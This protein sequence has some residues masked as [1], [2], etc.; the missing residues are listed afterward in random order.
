MLLNPEEYPFCANKRRENQ[1]N[2]E[3]NSPNPNNVS[4]HL[5]WEREQVTN[6]LALKKFDTGRR[7]HLESGTKSKQLSCKFQLFCKGLMR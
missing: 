7:P 5:H 1:S 4:H 2:S 6:C 3:N